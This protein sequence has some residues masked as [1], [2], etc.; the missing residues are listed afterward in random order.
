LAANFYRFA[1][2]TGHLGNR[3]HFCSSPGRTEEKLLQSNRL[4]LFDVI[5]ACVIGGVLLVLVPP[6]EV[7]AT[8]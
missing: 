4:P 5:V 7:E 8:A 2:K 1:E 6:R 3:S